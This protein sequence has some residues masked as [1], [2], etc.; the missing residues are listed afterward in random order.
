[1][2][3]P[4][5][6]AGAWSPAE[7]GGGIPSPPG[8]SITFRAY[9]KNGTLFG[10]KIVNFA[11]DVEEDVPILLEPVAGNPGTLAVTLPYDDRIAINAIGEIDRYTFATDPGANYEVQVARN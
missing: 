4:A 6:A 11:S 2:S 10:T 7:G 5:W 3:S 1:M 8:P 9:A